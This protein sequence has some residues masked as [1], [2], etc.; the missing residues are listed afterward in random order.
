MLIRK[1]IFLYIFLYILIKE[2]F[3]NLIK[4]MDFIFGKVV[5]IYIFLYNLGDVEIFSFLFMDMN[6]I[7]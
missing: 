4:V 5:N 3:K 6:R 7:F 2:F 1:F